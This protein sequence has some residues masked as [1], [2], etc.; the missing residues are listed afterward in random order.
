VESRLVREHPVCTVASAALDAGNNARYLVRDLGAAEAH[1]AEGLAQHAYILRCGSLTHRLLHNLASAVSARNCSLAI[2]LY[3][4]AALF[5]SLDAPE[6]RGDALSSLLNIALIRAQSHPGS[7]A[8][9]TAWEALLAHTRHDRSLSILAA[10][11]GVLVPRAAAELQAASAARDARMVALLAA[12]AGWAQEPPAAHC[13]PQNFSHWSPLWDTPYTTLDRQASLQLARR[14]AT[15]YAR[16][17]R[18]ALQRDAV[19]IARGVPDPVQPSLPPRVRVGFAGAFLRSSHSLGKHI[20]GVIHALPRDDFHV[21]TIVFAD[22]AADLLPTP[23]GSDDAVLII[24]A[25]LSSLHETQEQ[26]ARLQ[27][28]VLIFPDLGASV[29]PL[30][31]FVTGVSIRTQ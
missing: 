10:T 14:T 27:L 22:H 17:C 16:A 9:E 5:A 13:T 21:T 31:C 30:P 2:A 25:R 8:E 26:I 19:G 29:P 24:P 12:S 28:D 18:G 15:L 6:W 20:G 23:P 7:S 11:R 1:Y 3:S 4:R